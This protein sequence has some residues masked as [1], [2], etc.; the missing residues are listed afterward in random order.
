[1]WLLIHR[2]LRFDLISNLT[3]FSFSSFFLVDAVFN[4]NDV[5]NIIE[6]FRILEATI[7]IGGSV[8]LNTC[9]GVAPIFF[10]FL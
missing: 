3:L 1:M 9:S 4:D 8:V 7:F 2:S 10:C 6:I 5:T